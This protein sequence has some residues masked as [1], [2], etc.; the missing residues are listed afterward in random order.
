MSPTG[1]NNVGSI[2]QALS[3][4]GN[5]DYDKVEAGK[6][7]S[8]QVSLVSLANCGARIGIGESYSILLYEV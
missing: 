5:P 7:Q 3:A 8:A 4:K 2:A 1:I 6:L